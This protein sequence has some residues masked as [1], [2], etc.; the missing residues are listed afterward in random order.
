[1]NKSSQAKVLLAE[2]DRILSRLYSAYLKQKNFQ[3]LQ[4]F[5]GGQIIDQAK[6]FKPDIII[7][8]LIMPGMDG[9]DVLPRIRQEE[10]LKDIPVCVFSNL[11]Q[12]EDIEKAKQLGADLYLNKSQ[13]EI[14]ELDMHINK[15]LQR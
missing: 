14:E 7:L 4:V 15:L 11:A 3:V 1:M 12:P 13:I 10:S 6:L 8:D 2:D 9:F 5:H